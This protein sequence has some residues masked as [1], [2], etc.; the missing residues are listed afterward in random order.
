MGGGGG[1]DGVAEL[2]GGA[3][4]REVVV[5]RKAKDIA[6]W[7]TADISHALNVTQGRMR[8]T[9]LMSPAPSWASITGPM[10]L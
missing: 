10:G 8:A 2:H 9:A 6:P 4:V 7:P 3:I 5:I 1:L